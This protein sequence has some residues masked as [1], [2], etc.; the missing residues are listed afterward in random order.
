MYKI[1]QPWEV[2][3]LS[4][5]PKLN[6]YYDNNNNNTNKP[7]NT[8]NP[9]SSDEAENRNPTANNP[10]SSMFAL[11]IGSWLRSRRSRLF[12]LL[13]CSPVLLPLLFACFPLLCAAEVCIRICRR[14]TT[15]SVE[16]ESLRRCEEGCCGCGGGD[17]DEREV[18]LLQRYL[19]DQLML[20]GS[21]YECADHDDDDDD[22]E[23]DQH[24]CRTPLL[25]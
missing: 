2:S 19:E 14:R 25:S 16:D 1:Q 6:Y 3:F 15:K 18:G 7:I 11:A 21:V 12:F 17:E 8:Q 24:D 10:S 9:N 4:P 13:L 20:V 23:G 5:N 22:D